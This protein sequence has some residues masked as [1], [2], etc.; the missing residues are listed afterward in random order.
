[1]NRGFS[2]LSILYLVLLVPQHL[3]SQ[4]TFTTTMNGDWDDATTWGGTNPAIEG[5]NYP[6]RSDHAV[7]G[8]IVT[9]D[10]VTDN[11]TGGG[12]RPDRLALNENIIGVCGCTTAGA[13]TGCVNN[14]PEDGANAMFYHA[15]DITINN[16]GILTSDISI[17]IGG[18]ATVNSGGSMVLTANDND[19]F[20][21]NR[22][23][24]RAGGSFSVADN[25]SISA[26]SILEIESGTT[27]MD[28]GDDLF[29]DGDNG[30]L[31][32]DGQLDV[33]NTDTGNAGTNSVRLVNNTDLNT[34][35]Q[36]CAEMTVTCT[37][38]GDC[39]G[40]DCSTDVDNTAGG[41]GVIAPDEDDGVDRPAEEV[42]L[43]VELLFFV[44]EKNNNEIILEW[45]TSSEL[46]ND[47]FTVERRINENPWEQIALIN[48]QGTIN[49][50]TQYRYT[51]PIQLSGKMYYKLSQTDFDGT[52]VVL[53]TLSLSEFNN[54]LDVD[55]FPNPVLDQLNIVVKNNIELNSLVIVD[56]SGKQHNDFQVK[57]H[58]NII[59]LIF[60][61]S[62]TKS[63]LYYLILSSNEGAFSKRFIIK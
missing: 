53:K 48:G 47:F 39:C 18:E 46:N 49:I 33:D 11:N 1:M 44:A 2:T 8:H 62:S 3:F 23:T 50:E 4:A 51:D 10:A 15:G 45:A 31:C 30:V 13:T 24:V 40:A 54:E 37:G 56:M 9:I 61:K 57:R 55:L 63:G 5:T 34:L 17:I 36:I 19:V 43:P 59:S 42:I 7:I 58:G 26:S 25:L 6:S 22:L 41:D 35:D 20:V 27:L 52:R 32:G 21:I 38:G 29:F 28:V 16:S 14:V 12:R 60:S